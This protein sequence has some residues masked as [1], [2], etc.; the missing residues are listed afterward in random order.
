M[1]IRRQC[2][3]RH[4]PRSIS[5]PLIRCSTR[6]IA[7]GERLRR[8]AGENSQYRRQELTGPDP[9]VD[10]VVIIDE[11]GY[12]PLAREQVVHQR[13]AELS[14]ELRLSAIPDLYL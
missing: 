1:R 10:G 11:I 8:R 12:L 14:R 13:L 9:V 6:Q 3:T 7:A 2:A 5:P 4:L